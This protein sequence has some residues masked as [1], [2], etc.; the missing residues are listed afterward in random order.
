MPAEANREEPND[1]ETRSDLPRIT[2]ARDGSSAGE[3]RLHIAAQPGLLA[4]RRPRR[5]RRKTRLADLHPDRP[6]S[7]DAAQGGRVP[8][9]RLECLLVV[10]VA[11]HR[12]RILRATIFDHPRAPLLAHLYRRY[13]ARSHQGADLQDYRT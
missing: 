3:L 10:P 1:D 11:A 4:T 7:D 9:L 2:E 12:P 5:D 8:S 6:H 13:Q